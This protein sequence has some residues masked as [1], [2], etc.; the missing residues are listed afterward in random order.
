[1]GSRVGRINAARQI[2]RPAGE[3]A[4]SRDDAWRKLNPNLATTKLCDGRSRNFRI[5]GNKATIG[6]VLPS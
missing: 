2:P 1:M 6:G 5:S 4:G 3:N